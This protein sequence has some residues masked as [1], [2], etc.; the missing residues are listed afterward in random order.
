MVW[1][2][3]WWQSTFQYQVGLGYVRDVTEPVPQLASGSMNLSMTA[4]IILT[5]IRYVS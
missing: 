2:Y 1:Y 5:L 4:L 3:S